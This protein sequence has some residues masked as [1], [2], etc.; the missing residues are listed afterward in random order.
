[1]TQTHEEDDYSERLARKVIESGCRRWRRNFRSA[2]SSMSE[3]LKVR[4]CTLADP[5]KQPD[6]PKS[7]CWDNHWISPGNRH[8]GCEQRAKNYR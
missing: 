2:V 4:A 3:F 1:M 7:K 8:A 5:E 6:R